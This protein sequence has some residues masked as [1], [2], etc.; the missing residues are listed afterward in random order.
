MPF[1]LFR[2]YIG[3]VQAFLIGAVAAAA[4]AAIV[5]RLE[6]KSGEPR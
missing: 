4:A 2:H 3:A 1:T 5:R 6:A